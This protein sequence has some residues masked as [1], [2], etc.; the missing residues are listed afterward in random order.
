[1]NIVVSAGD[2]SGIGP[3]LLVRLLE[4]EPQWLERSSFQLTGPPAIWRFLGLKESNRLQFCGKDVDAPLPKAGTPCETGAKIQRD[5]LLDAMELMAL[6]HDS[7]LL[8]LPVNK[9]QLVASGLNFM[10][11]TD[12]FRSL[13]PDISITM[14]FRSDGYWLGLVTDHVA[15][16]QVPDQL[17]VQ[18]VVQATQHVHQASRKPVVIC[19]LNPHAGEDGLMGD[20]ELGLEAAIT[21][22]HAQN[23]P[24]RGFVAAD[25]FFAH[26]NQSEAVIALYHDQG[27]GPFKARF[28]GRSCQISLGMPF[29]RV[30]PDHGTAYELAGTGRATTGSLRQALIEAV[31]SVQPPSH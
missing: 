16:C 9:R 4:S 6:Q 19:G 1:M 13:Y 7:T 30:S 10:G 17:T 26:W 31:D 14:A 11:H 24:C 21:Q 18:R 23:I 15:L 22:L 25:S 2:P 12:Y 20:E 29:R 8:T 5:A 3:E 28:H 27:L